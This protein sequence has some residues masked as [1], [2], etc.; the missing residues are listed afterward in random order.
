MRK[1]ADYEEVG[2]I[3][4]PR[5]GEYVAMMDSRP[6]KDRLLGGELCGLNDAALE[7]QTASLAKCYPGETRLVLITIRGNILVAVRD[8]H[9]PSGEKAKR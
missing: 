5:D 2:L 1:L 4:Y 8:H 7:D 6:G 3:G 9:L